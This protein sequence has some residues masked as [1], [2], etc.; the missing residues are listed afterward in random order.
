MSPALEDDN[1]INVADSRQYLS[2]ILAGEEYAVDILRVQEIRGWSAVTLI[3]NTPDY[4]KGVL[5]LRGA[6]IPVIDMR[7]RFQLPPMTYDATTVVVVLSVNSGDRQRIMG[8]VVDAVAETYDVVM[9]QVRQAPQ[10]NSAINAEFITGLTSVDG[11]MVILLDVDQIL[12][13]AEL[14]LSAAVA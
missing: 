1:G 14:A 3:P 5:N 7:L 12:N 10:L 9:D 13:S 2:F 6:V 8:L 4:I 11:K